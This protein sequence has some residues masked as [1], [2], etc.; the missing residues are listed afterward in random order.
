MTATDLRY[1]LPGIGTCCGALYLLWRFPNWHHPL[2]YLMTYVWCFLLFAAGLWVMGFGPS[3]T[4]GLVIC[5][6][7][8]YSFVRF[9]PDSS[10]GARAMGYLLCLMLFS[11][12]IFIINK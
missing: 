1:I 9:P 8:F 10:P 3:R 11:S 6:S 12:G 2:S 5:V 4:W 7:A